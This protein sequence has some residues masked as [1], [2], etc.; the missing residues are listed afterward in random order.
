MGYYKE[1]SG[2]TAGEWYTFRVSFALATNVES[3]M[4]GVGGSPGTSVYVKGGVVSVKPECSVNEQNQ[5]R[6]NIDKGNQ[7]VGGGDM[8]LL[9]NLEKA[10]V[11]A[12]GEYEWK[13]FA[14]TVR[15]KANAQGCVYLIVGTDSG[16]EAVSAYYLDDFS[17]SW[18][19]WQETEVIRKA[20]G[21][22]MKPVVWWFG[23]RG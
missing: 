19:K 3:G 22:L 10:E 20:I 4:I 23:L 15:A 5:Y 13:T 21:E 11:R 16:F 8:L 7:G 12:P 6:M 17:V 1:I 9:G 18:E 14:F 2:L